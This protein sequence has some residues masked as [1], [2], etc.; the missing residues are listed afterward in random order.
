MLE[1]KFESISI[2]GKLI[3]FIIALIL[4][5]ISINIYFYKEINDLVDEY[6]KLTQDYTQVN[7]LS[8]QLI[9]GREYVSK[10][11]TSGAK[12]MNSGDNEELS[13]FYKNM[14]QAIDMSDRIYN[15]SNTM[16]TYVLSKA[17]NNSIK[18][19]DNEIDKAIN[20]MNSGQSYYSQ[21]LEAADISNY[22]IG[23]TKSL[24]D[25]KLIEGQ[26]YH[27]QLSNRI[28]EIRATNLMVFSS[29]MIFSLLYVIVFS[30]SIAVPIRELSR[31]AIKIAE[32]ELPT[33]ELNIK[34]SYEINTLVLA[35]NKMTKG[36]QRMIELEREINE[37]KLSRVIMSKQLNEAK[38]LALQSQINPHFLFNSLNTIAKVSMFENANKTSELIQSLSDIFRYNLGSGNKEVLL[39]EE[40]DIIKQYIFIQKTR[41]GPRIGFDI[42][43]KGDIEDIMIPRFLIEPL[44]EN[45][46]VHGIEP[47]ESGGSVRTKIYKKD[48]ETVIK[49]IDNGVGMSKEKLLEVLYGLNK[50]ENHMGQSTGIGVTNVRDRVILYCRDDRSFSIHSAEGIGTVITIRLIK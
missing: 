15:N 33:A 38:F 49:I 32:G 34:S 30:N 6:N 8:I 5:I 4:P 45:S 28:S 1:L 12:Y 47:K 2:R 41:F 27:K 35:F 23:Y 29:M 14:R 20:Q 46:V 16:D 3:I 37:D 39:T 21:F 24:L 42:V 9:N 44:V 7:N 31:N 17:I 26:W 43:L 22:I 11:M 19:Y 48:C 25:T 50:N 18:T 10:Y 36:I 13:A 40:L